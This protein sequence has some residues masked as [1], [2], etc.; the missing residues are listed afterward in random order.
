MLYIL[1]VFIFVSII[2]IFYMVYTAHHDTI[3]YRTVHDDKLNHGFRLFFIADIH[4]RTVKGDAISSIHENIDIVVVGGDL[5]EKGVPIERTRDNILKLK[6]L[7]APIY[8]IWGN[9]DYEALPNR[10]YELLMEQNVTILANQNDDVT[11][12]NNRVS[13]IGLDCCQYREA[14]VDLAME[15][16]EGEYNILLTHAPSAFYEL[17][18]TSQRKLDVVLAGHTHG[19]QIRILGFGFFEKGGLTKFHNTTIIVTEGYGYTKLPFRLGTKSE[20][21]VLTFVQ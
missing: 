14:R 7:D 21:H 2:F 3:D 1:S 16:A 18:E 5:T 4:R 19:G 10:I 8:F 20:C 17:D 9:N 12:N 11:I 6:Q 15:N 13:F